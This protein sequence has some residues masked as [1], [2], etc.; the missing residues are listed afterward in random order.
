MKKIKNT[1]LLVVLFTVCSCDNYLDVVPD[2]VATIDNAF[3]D[4]VQARK[5]LFTCYS[6]LPNFASMSSNPAF[7]G[8]DE[9]WVLPELRR[10][11]F[12]NVQNVA[13][14]FQNANDPYLNYYEGLLGASDDL[15][16]G[17]R[18]CNTFIDRIE[19]VPDM[20]D[21]E[22]SRWKAE[23]KFLKAYYHFYLM[24]MYGPVPLIDKNL[25]VSAN[26]DEVKAVRA[27][28]D[29]GIN[30]VV[31]LLDEAA[32]DLPSNVP[33]EVDELGRITKP[34]ALAIKAKVLVTAASP[35]FNG[36][37]DYASLVNNDGT[38][39]FST[40]EDPEK[41]TRAA[42]ATQEAITAAE[43]AGHSLYQLNDP[44]ISAFSDFN[45]QQLSL[46]GRVTD[47][48]NP[49]IIWGDSGGSGATN[50]LQ[51]YAQA[52]LI[53]GVGNAVI[54]A[55]APTLRTAK[56]YHTENGVPINED[57]AWSGKDVFAYRVA[58]ADEAQKIRPGEEIPE[59]HFDREARFYADVGFDRGVWFGQ[60]N[61]D[62][63]NPYFVRARV[64]ETSGK[65]AI[66]EYS[67]TGYFAKK[68]V[69]YKNAFSSGNNYS[70][71]NYAFP[72]LRL[73]DLYLLHAE[74]LNESGQL[75]EAQTWVDKIRERAGL[76]GVVQ[77]WNDHAINANK[78]ASKDG[79]RDI[80]QQERLIEL[81]MEGHRFW[82]IR[83]WKRAVSLMNAPIQG[84]NG[85]SGE[86]QDEFYSVIDLQEQSFGTK[87]YLWPL[88]TYT[89]T[90]N[91]NLVQNPGW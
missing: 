62:E 40:A 53:N 43:A 47:R 42:E 79:L 89:L 64:G 83:R 50:Q 12:T 13:L 21:I 37:A 63:A 59:L 72:I 86:S 82:D 57:R 23:A 33:D 78:P 68:L 70:V 75:A 6:F 45:K 77:S 49:E 15:Y 25:P 30:F 4:R 26:P 61:L 36:N 19:E 14:G 87:D 3:F 8:G 88:R 22:K 39:L 17:I 41:W 65:K 20:D 71:T 67:I 32:A 29:E 34:I 16:G 10:R 85:D 80:I 91:T 46:R 2:N 28:F 56:L 76:E 18:I 58:T 38:A 74:A 84:W 51:R 24:R 35:L 48:W 27:P 54:Q 44:T 9:L 5:Y 7:L 11:N 60:G 66:D 52:K 81:S 55:L 90:V 1:I 73:A 69:Y 31:N